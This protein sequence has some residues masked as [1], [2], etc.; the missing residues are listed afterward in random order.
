M[1]VH[2]FSVPLQRQGENEDVYRLFY[3]IVGF[4]YRKKGFCVLVS[5][6]QRSFERVMCDR[7]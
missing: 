3:Q 4:Y 7:N 6:S 5:L 2:A 1:P